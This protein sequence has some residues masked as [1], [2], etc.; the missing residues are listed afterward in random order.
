[1]ELLKQPQYAPFSMER[2]VVSVWAGTSGQLDDVP[3]RDIKRFE[4]EFLENVER[5]HAGVMT[6]IRE[7][8]NCPTTP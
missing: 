3:L 4:A 7:T 6:T 8:G 1:M 2:E 5:E